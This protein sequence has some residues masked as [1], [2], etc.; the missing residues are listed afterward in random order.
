MSGTLAVGLAQVNPIVGD[1]DA[2]VGRIL[3]LRAQAP[4]CD[5]LVFGELTLAGYPPEDLVLKRIF[6][7]RIEAAAQM[8][9]AETSDGGPALLVGAPWRQDS[10]LYNAPCCWMPAYR[11]AAIQMRIAELWSIRRKADICAWATFRN[12]LHFGV[13]VLA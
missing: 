12:R 13:H 8:L 6:Q 2:N 7:E 9:A 5:L 4:D 1:V 3:A 10:R 11:R